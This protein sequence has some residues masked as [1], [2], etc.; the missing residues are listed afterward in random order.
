[1]TTRASLNND[2]L[3]RLPIQVPTYEEQKKIGDIL[4][5]F[6]KKIKLN[7]R[8]NLYFHSRCGGKLSFIIKI[9]KEGV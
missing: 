5:S 7:H 6:D 9:M 8:I 3:S 2:I 4:Y 1:M